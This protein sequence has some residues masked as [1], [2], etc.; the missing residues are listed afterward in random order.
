MTR[1]LVRAVQPS[2]ESLCSLRRDVRDLLKDAASLWLVDE[3]LLALDEA[4]T[5]ALLHGDGRGVTVHV[6]I[7]DETVTLTIRDSG[8]GFDIAGL[9][10]GWPPS[11]ALEGGRGIY[12]ATRLMDAVTI[13]FAGGTIVHMS[14][15]LAAD[16]EST[17]PVCVCMG[18]TAARFA[19]AV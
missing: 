3:L 5:N 11:P 13:S 15:A 14:R 1:F 8:A 4:V 10:E 12:I 17:L 19:R 2:S 18:P 7:D 16:R 9:V 6:G